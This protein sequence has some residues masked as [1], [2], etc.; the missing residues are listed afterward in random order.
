MNFYAFYGSKKIENQNPV[1]RW[2]RY[3]PL[4][5]FVGTEHSATATEKTLSGLLSFIKLEIRS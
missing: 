2:L 1:L 3:T 4:P 5:T